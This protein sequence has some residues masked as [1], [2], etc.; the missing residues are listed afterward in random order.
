MS[1][2]VVQVEQTPG[3][4]NKKS[5]SAGGEHWPLQSSCLL[6]DVLVTFE[7]WWCFTRVVA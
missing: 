7:C 4:V 2:V 5:G 1:R 3:G 6:A